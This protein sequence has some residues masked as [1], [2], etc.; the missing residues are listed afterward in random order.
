MHLIHPAAARTICVGLLFLAC[1]F[2]SAS[3][4]RTFTDQRD[5]KIVAKVISV[6]DDFAL[7]ELKANG[8]QSAVPFDVLSDAD[9]EYLT[10]LDVDSVDD[11]I[12]GNDKSVQN[13]EDIAA[14]RLYPRSKQEIRDGIREIEKT[15]LPKGLSRD[16]HE[17]VKKLNIYRFL[18]GLSYDV[19]GDPTFSQNAE[20]AAKACAKN[21]GLSHDIGHHT[22]RCNLAS[23][24]SMLNS[25]SQYIEDSGDNNREARGHRA[26]CLNPPM[27]K[28]GFGSA[29]AQYSAMWCMDGSGAS[30]VKDFWTYPGRG[31]FPLEYMHGNAWSVYFHEPVPELKKITVEVFRVTKRPES[32]LSMSGEIEGKPIAVD[33]ISKSMMNGINFEPAKPAEKGIYWVRVKGGGLR[34]GYVVELY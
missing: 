3:E 6:G 26:W 28:V 11:K 13:P 32:P 8:R 7:L 18:C 5:R 9:V 15:P 12:A 30:K 21:G 24:G 2:L 20:Q 34:I 27:G 4:W 25:V 1:S 14:N 17:A 19:E 29:G 16:V 31:F 10:S 33:Y 22:D 23:D